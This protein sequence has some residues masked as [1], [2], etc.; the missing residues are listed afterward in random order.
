[1]SYPTLE[2]PIS[3]LPNFTMETKDDL[4]RDDMDGGYQSSRPRSTR[5]LLKISGLTFQLTNE[6]LFSLMTFYDQTT[7]KGS[8]PF[9]YALQV[10]NVDS[11]GFTSFG[12]KNF[13][14]TSPIK[15]KYTGMGV[16]EA[17]LEMEEV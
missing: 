2:I 5:T 4:I 10:L 8:L 14:F 9:S 15:Y 1:M 17:T 7:V 6:Q 13:S 3:P 11:P 16:W 12:S